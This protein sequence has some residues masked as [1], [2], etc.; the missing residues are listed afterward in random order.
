M[1]NGVEQVSNS[2][3]AFEG[4][5][6]DLFLFVVDEEGDGLGLA[7]DCFW[8][9][10]SGKFVHLIIVELEL[11]NI[12]FIIVFKNHWLFIASNHIF[13]GLR[14]VTGIE[15]YFLFNKDDKITSKYKVIFE[16]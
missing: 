9:L 2:V 8:W 6:Q 13:Y 3:I 1:A 15:S 7:R 5:S 4:D 10:V 14:K 11:N 16:S 12:T